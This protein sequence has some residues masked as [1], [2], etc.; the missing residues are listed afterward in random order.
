MLL[1]VEAFSFPLNKRKCVLLSFFLS[2]V[3]INQDFCCKVSSIENIIELKKQQPQKQK[4]IMT[5]KQKRDIS[6]IFS[7]A[8]NVMQFDGLLLVN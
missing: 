3:A 4:T 5:R 7:L 6:R 2:S 1:Y 8:M